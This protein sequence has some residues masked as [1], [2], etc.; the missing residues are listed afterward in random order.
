MQWGEYRKEPRDTAELGSHEHTGSGLVSGSPS[1]GENGTSVGNTRTCWF[2]IHILLELIKILDLSK[3]VIVP[4]VCFY[5]SS[6]I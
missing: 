2:S 3:Q 1:R 5:L 4:L 6:A